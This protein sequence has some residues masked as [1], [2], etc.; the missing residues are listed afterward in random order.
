MLGSIRV[1]GRAVSTTS[2]EGP[3]LPELLLASCSGPAQPG[4]CALSGGGRQPGGLLGVAGAMRALCLLV[5]G[6]G[7]LP[8]GCSEVFGPELRMQVLGPACQGVGWLGALPPT[9]TLHWGPQTGASGA[10]ALKP[11]RLLPRTGVWSAPGLGSSQGRLAHLLAYPR[12]PGSRKVILGLARPGWGL[13]LPGGSGS[14]WFL[15]A[16]AQLV[17]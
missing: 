3:L 11:G 7:T 12:C 8:P 5:T 14:G 16:P 1:G 6:A 2:R 4:A 15:V 13:S 17:T 9:T 10:G